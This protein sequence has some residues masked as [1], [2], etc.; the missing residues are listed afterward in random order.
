[1]MNMLRIS[2]ILAQD[3]GC[4][5]KTRTRDDGLQR[6]SDNSALNRVPT[7]SRPHQDRFF[8]KIAGISRKMPTL[9][10]RHRHFCIIHPRITLSSN[11]SIF[12]T[13]FLQ[14]LSTHIPAPALHR[15]KHTD[16]YIGHSPVITNH[17]E[18]SRDRVVSYPHQGTNLRK[19]S[20]LKLFWQT[21]L[22][23]SFL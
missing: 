13:Y 14:K 18:Q 12:Q 21:L 22:E 7:L 15:Q 11:H 5:Y 17:L 10:I 23:Q 1:M 3:N 8:V 6:L 9:P 16:L 2:Q 19:G 4:R 20:Y